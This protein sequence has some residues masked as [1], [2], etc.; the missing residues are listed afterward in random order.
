[1]RAGLPP[2]AAERLKRLRD[3]ELSVAGFKFGFKVDSVG[4]EGGATLAEAFTQVVDQAGC[5][6]VLIVDEVPSTRPS[7]PSPPTTAT[8]CCLH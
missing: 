8:R 7:T 1:M 3:A 6:I 2:A 4:A 5:D